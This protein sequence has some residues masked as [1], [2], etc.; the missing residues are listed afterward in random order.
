MTTSPSDPIHHR[1]VQVYKDERLSQLDSIPEFQSHSSVLTKM[2]LNRIV[3]KRELEQ[4]ESSLAPHQRAVMADGLTIVERGVLEHNMVAVGQLYSSIYFAQLGEL[5]GVVDAVKAERVAAKM[6][7][8]GSLSGSIDEVEG[9][10]H[11]A[12][13]RERRGSTLLRWDETIT[14][15]CVQLNKVTDAVRSSS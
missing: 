4:F 1:F 12:S 9:I 3:Q 14:S 5:L 6:M 10:L 15:F 7:S 13:P 8:D 2:Y 11:F